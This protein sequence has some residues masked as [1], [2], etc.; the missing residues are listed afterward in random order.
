MGFCHDLKYEVEDLE[1]A[2]D[3]VKKEQLDSDDEEEE[4]TPGLKELKELTVED[5]E[6]T[7]NA[8]QAHMFIV[9]ELKR[10]IEHELYMA[11]AAAISGWGAVSVLENKMYAN[12]SGANAAEKELKTQKIRKATETFAK[13]QRLHKKGEPSNGL[14]KLKK[15][16]NHLHGFGFKKFGPK[17]RGY[18]GYGGYSGVAATVDGQGGYDQSYGGGFGGGYGGGESHRG[19][20]GYGNRGAGGARGGCKP[21]RSCHRSVPCLR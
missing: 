4:M 3:F 7:N 17:L 8:L 19:R 6:K 18:G 11:E 12:I 10:K 2:W 15:R 14:F 20:G 5:V 13:E 21:T 9:A 16:P 1:D